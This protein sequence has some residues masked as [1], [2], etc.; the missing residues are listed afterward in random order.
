[1]P[2]RY[3]NFPRL[4]N[5]VAEML[6]ICPHGFILGQFLLICTIIVH[7]SFVLCTISVQFKDDI[8]TGYGNTIPSG[9]LD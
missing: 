6:V 9:N 5:K 2:Q 1:M 8:E 4:P 7:F 3:E